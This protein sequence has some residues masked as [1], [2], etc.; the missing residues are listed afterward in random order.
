MKIKDSALVAAANLS[1]RYIADRFLPDKAID[2][3]DEAA[4]RLAMEFQSVP[5]PIDEVQRRLVQLELAERQLADETEEH[6]HQRREEIQE[7]MADLRRRLADLRKQWELEKSGLGD[8]HHVRQQLDEAQLQ[9]NQLAAGIKEKQS[10]GTLVPESD[11]QKLYELDLR[12]KKLS[13]QLDSADKPQAPAA[14]RR[15]LRSEVGPEEIAEVVSAWTGIPVSR[16]MET[17]RAKL[18]VLEERIHQR[19]VDQEEAVRPWP[20]PSAATAAACKTPTGPSA[21]S[22]SW[23]PPAWARPSC[24][25]PW[26]R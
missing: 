21:R 25:R 15:L 18:L 16:M 3:M 13:E 4:S 24:A 5:Q 8:V 12:R 2:L 14:G 19:L 23:G 26:P 10:A 17:E 20:T 11:Y 1:H 22:S 9:F 6:A 7:E